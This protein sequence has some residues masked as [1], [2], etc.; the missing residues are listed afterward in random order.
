MVVAA[1]TDLLFASKIRAAAQALGIEVRFARTAEEILALARDGS[2]RLVMIDLN[3]RDLDPLSAIARLKEASAGACRIVG[4]VSHVHGELIAAARR[5]GA[6]DV[7]AR[8]A[9]AAQLPSL[10]QAAR[11]EASA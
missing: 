7:L 4:F 8:S 10:L 5:A 9:F 1:V 11:G 3:S 2:A 6:D